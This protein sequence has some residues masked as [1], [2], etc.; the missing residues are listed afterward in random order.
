MH[1]NENWHLE[2]HSIILLSTEETS[3]FVVQESNKPGAKMTKNSSQ[4]WWI[5]VDFFQFDETL[6]ASSL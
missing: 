6:R 2:N 3:F 1:S 4:C 5:S